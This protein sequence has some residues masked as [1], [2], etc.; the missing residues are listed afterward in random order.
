MEAAA[1]R[2]G[3]PFGHSSA[4]NGVLVG[5]AVGALIGT[6]ILTGG[7]SLIA[8]GAAV[9]ITG[10]AGLAG[11]AI[12]QTIEGDDSGMI[13]TGSPDVSV[14][15]R[16]AAMTVAARGNCSH[17]SGAPVPVATGAAT[18]FINGQPAA[19]VGEKMSCS[20]VIRRGS[21]TVFIGGPSKQMI[22]PAPEVP[23]LLQDAMLAMVIGGT[24]IGTL[25]VAMT[26]GIGAA[27]GSLVGG[28]GGSFALGHGASAVA[29]KMG[30]GATGQAVAGVVGSVVGGSV[31]GAAGLGRYGN[32]GGVSTSEGTTESFPVVFDG[33]FATKQ[34]LGTDTTPGGRQ[35]MFHAADRMVNPPKGRAPMSPSEVDDVLDGATSVVKRSYHPNGDTLT[36]ENAN[37]DGKPRV[38]VDEATGQ[39][40]ITVIN[41]RRKM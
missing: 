20:A 16:A 19:R 18:V 12:G 2:V 10:G 38:I 36:I 29:A 7:V 35:I 24:A 3:D 5:L 30:Y 32:S 37:L 33:G 9:A 15:G 27:I 31:F 25:G 14:D 40:V 41:P 21:D 22:T 1:A 26:Y 13:E 34:L 17:D 8:V 4:M 11:E 39:R 6:A 23:A 28:T